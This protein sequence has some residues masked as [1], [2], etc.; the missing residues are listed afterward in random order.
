MHLI[1]TNDANEI[2]GVLSKI[3]IGMI[4]Q[5]P[6][7]IL[8]LATGSSPIETYKLLIAD[9][10]TN[11]TDWSKVVTFNLD[12]YVG[13]QQDNKNSYYY[14]MQENL[15]KHLNIK[16]EN[17]HIPNGV[18]DVQQ[19]AID[20]ETLVASKEPI[21]FQLLGIGSNGHIGFNEPGSD[22]NCQTRVVKLSE[23]TIDANK[24]FFNLEVESV[25]SK[26]ITMGIA[27][28]LKAKTIVLIATGA[29]KAEAVKALVQGEVSAQW[30]CT[31]L[32]NHRNVIVFADQQAASL[33]EKNQGET[34]A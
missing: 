28:I 20:Y 16:Q 14:F 18:G 17:I 24:R 2:A 21:D 23:E 31:Y 11:K 22:V 12:E 3:I 10:E 8:G 13:L 1:V 15:F 9:H 27:T 32:Q 25:P 29:N 34:N 19:N 4:K 5:K 33:L 30:P 7:A 6:N 26:A